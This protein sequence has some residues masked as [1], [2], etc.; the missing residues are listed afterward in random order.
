MTDLLGTTVRVL[1]AGDISYNLVNNSAS[2]T[3]STELHKVSLFIF[4]YIDTY[5][6]NYTM[7]FSSK[8]F[9]K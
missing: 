7:L 1:L 8:L 2:S 9:F 3:N 5:H 6:L 4:L